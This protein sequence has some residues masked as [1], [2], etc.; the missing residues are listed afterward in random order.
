MKILGAILAGGQSRRFG[1]DK[2]VASYRGAPL[3]AHMIDALGRQCD[4]ILICGRRIEGYDM[5]PDRPAPGLG[6]LG[7]LA[8]ALH[9]GQAR[10]FDAVLSVPCDAPQIPHDLRAQLGAAP[11]C[12]AD[13]PVIGLWPCALADQL[14]RH[15]AADPRRS[16]RGWADRIGAA[17]RTL[18]VPIANINTPADLAAIEAGHG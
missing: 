9:A 16:M 7:G 10:G 6:P 12:L 17:R 18:A 5:V 11:A 14:D 15:V 8:A 13:L 2:A 4:A 1:S 3:I